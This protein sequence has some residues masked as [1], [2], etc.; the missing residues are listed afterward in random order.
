MA[1]VTP[2]AKAHS[3]L[4]DLASRYVDVDELPWESTRFDG[5]EIKTL[6]I[7]RESGLLTTLVR[8]AP[9]ATLPDH[10]HVAIEQ[11]YVL[12]GSLVDHEGEV[13]AGEY[14]WRPGGSRHEATAPNGGL[15]LSFFL[16]PNRFFDADGATDISGQAYDEDAA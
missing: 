8:M 11:T 10:E 1:T 13:R 7:D 14:V 12:E 15:F 6:M 16:K 3:G 4:A 9:G 5:V 2:N